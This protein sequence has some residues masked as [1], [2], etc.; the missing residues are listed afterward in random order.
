MSTLNRPYLWDEEAAFKRLE[1]A[2]WPDGP[3]CPH[4]GNKDRIYVLEGVRSK[5][6]KKNP[7][8]IVRHGLKKCGACRKQFT[9]RMGT[10]FESSHVALH[11][12]MQ[13]IHLMVSSKKGVSAH[14]LHRTLE[15][16]YRS[17]WFLAHRIR[18]AMRTGELAP[19]GGPGAIVEID[20]TFIG[21]T[22]GETKRAGGYAHK[23]AVLSL[24][25]RGGEVRSFQIEKANTANIKPIVDANL[26][27]ESMLM[28]DESRYYGKLGKGFKHHFTVDH[29]SGEY[30]RGGVHVNTLESYFSV[31]K[32][33]MKGVYQHCSERHLHRYLAEFDFRYNNRVAKGVN[34]SARADLALL[35]VVGKRLTYRDSFGQ[36]EC[37]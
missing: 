4:C 15:I 25:E 30:V 12:W 10:V 2:I 31:F 24:V 16:T 32:R 21:K 7:E 19:M 1:A 11:K 27:K 18:E 29:G 20:E 33:G 26:S 23:Q 28:T 22:E 36:E 13:A 35:G 34:D 17:A 3:V 37:S 9:A 8:G 14:Q 5:P 6:S